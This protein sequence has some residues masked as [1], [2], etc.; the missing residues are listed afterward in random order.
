LRWRSAGVIALQL[1]VI[2]ADIADA[3]IGIR[4]PGAGLPA[5]R[6]TAFGNERRAGPMDL[7]A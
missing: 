7:L 5:I 4:Q 6:P 3:F 2:V 1:A